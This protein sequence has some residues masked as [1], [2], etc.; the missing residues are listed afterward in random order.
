[1]IYDEV[2]KLADEHKVSIWK[3]ERDLGLSNG[4]ISKWNS[5]TPSSVS[6]QKVAEYFDVSVAYILKQ[7]NKGSVK[8][9]N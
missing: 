1:M 2:K 9:C 5:S 8:K 4:S 3:L 7:A 6:L